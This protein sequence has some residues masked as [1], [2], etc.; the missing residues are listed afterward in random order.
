MHSW[1][2]QHQNL[3]KKK[4]FSSLAHLLWT[5][6]WRKCRSQLSSYLV[7]FLSTPWWQSCRE[8]TETVWNIACLPMTGR[9]LTGRNRRKIHLADLSRRIGDPISCDRVSIEMPS[10]S[11]NYSRHCRERRPKHCLCTECLHNCNTIPCLSI[12]IAMTPAP[13]PL[14]LLYSC[15][16]LFVLGSFSTVLQHKYTGAPTNLM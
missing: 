1:Y 13:A 16:C 9:T 2:I 3:I 14:L 10:S 5:E 8:E 7:T 11:V 4:Q 6:R 15:T 12:S